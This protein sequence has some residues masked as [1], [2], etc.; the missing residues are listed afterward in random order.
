MILDDILARTRADLEVREQAQPLADLA[1]AAAQRYGETAKPVAALRIAGRHH[2]HR[3]VQTQV[4]VSGL[5]QREGVSRDHGS[6]LRGGRRQRALGADR[7]AVFA[8]RLTI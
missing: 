4:A 6:R 2:L 7:R 1:K 3:G 8:G 5:D